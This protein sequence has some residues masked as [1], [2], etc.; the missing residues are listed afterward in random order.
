MYLQGDHV[1]R[2]VGADIQASLQVTSN[3]LNCDQ[4]I[5]PSPPLS[6]L[7]PDFSCHNGRF[8]SQKYKRYERLNHLIS[9]DSNIF[10]PDCTLVYS[11]IYMYISRLVICEISLQHYPTQIITCLVYLQETANCQTRFYL[12]KIFNL[13][14]FQSLCRADTSMEETYCGD[15]T[16]APAATST[17]VNSVS[18][19]DGRRRFVILINISLCIAE[20]CRVFCIKHIVVY[21]ISLHG[22][23]SVCTYYGVIM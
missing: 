16:S 2:S 4:Q 22:S 19:R 9:M 14:N 3:I 8:C 12:Q 23:V 21:F 13:L 18:I 7:D 6:T 11:Y 17:P 20:Y 1:C 15:V 5:T 10:V